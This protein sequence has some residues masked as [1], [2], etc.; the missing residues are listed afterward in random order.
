VVDPPGVLL[1][2]SRG[3]AEETIVAGSYLSARG[4][5][6]LADGCGDF[7]QD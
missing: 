7:W 1:E 6:T 2:L 5:P 4:G 3:D